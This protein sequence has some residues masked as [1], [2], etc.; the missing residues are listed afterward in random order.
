MMKEKRKVEREREREMIPTAIL[1]RMPQYLLV[2][3]RKNEIKDILWNEL[4][5]LRI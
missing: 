2:L 5:E 3:F 4:N 1:S